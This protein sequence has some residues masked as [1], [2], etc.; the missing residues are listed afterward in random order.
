MRCALAML[1]VASAFI[2]GPCYFGC[3]SHP[4]PVR[5]TPVSAAGAQTHAA[6]ETPRCNPMSL[7]GPQKFNGRVLTCGPNSKHRSVYAIDY[8]TAFSGAFQ[9]LLPT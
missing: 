1:L 6:S 9:S 2:T 5:R 3:V 4:V 8:M 7:I